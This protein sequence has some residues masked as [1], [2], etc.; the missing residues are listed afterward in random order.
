MLGPYPRSKWLA[1]DH[2]RAARRD[3]LPVRI[4]IPTM[5]LGPGDSGFTPPT[6]MVLDFVCG[7]TPA[8]M[9]SMMN[10]ADVRDM[11]AQIVAMLEIDVPESGCFVG[12]KKPQALGVAADARGS[13]RCQDADGAGPGTRR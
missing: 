2:A 11:A 7:R 5:P 6:Q 8:Y 3:G 13:Q 9:E 12:G 1:E 4:A 10:V